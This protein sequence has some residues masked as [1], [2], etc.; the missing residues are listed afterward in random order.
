MA[1]E[2]KVAGI[3]LDAVNKSPILVLRDLGD[4]RARPIWIGRAEAS[5][6]VQALEGQKTTRPMTHDLFVNCL[7]GW[8]IKVIKIVIYSLQDSTFY[9][10]ISLEQGEQRKHLDARPSDAVALALRTR[11]PIWATEEV[12]AQASLPVDQDADNAERAAFHDFLEQIRPSDF[13][14]GPGLDTADWG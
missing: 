10:V 6:I 5:A 14:S 3:A 9:A 7:G 11:T 8:E 2:M 4:R 12:M 1:V 13:S